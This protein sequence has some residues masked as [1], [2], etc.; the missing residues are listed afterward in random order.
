MSSN[1]KQ[2]MLSASVALP[3]NSYVLVGW[4][5]V[6]GILGSS[7]CT[8]LKN[9]K[10]NPIRNVHMGKEEEKDLYV[11]TLLILLKQKVK[12]YMRIIQVLKMKSEDNHNGQVS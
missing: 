9:T 6:L 7:S 12:N 3:V 11:M 1:T 4:S 10:S 2:L 5:S 8:L